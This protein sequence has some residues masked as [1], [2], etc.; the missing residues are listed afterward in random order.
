MAE[1]H[2]GKQQVGQEAEEEG[3]TVGKSLYG[4]FPGKEWMRQ[5]KQFRTG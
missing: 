5:S 3:G 1:G 2:V 4:C